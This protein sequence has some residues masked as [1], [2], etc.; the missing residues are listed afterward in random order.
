MVYNKIYKVMES[1]MENGM[2]FVL[3]CCHNADDITLAQ[4][5]YFLNECY[6]EIIRYSDDESVRNIAMKRSRMLNEHSEHV[7]TPMITEVPQEEI[8]GLD[9]KY[10]EAIDRI[11]NT[12][13]S[14]DWSSAVPRVIEALKE[15]GNNI[16]YRTMALVLQLAMNVSRGNADQSLYQSLDS[17]I[18]ATT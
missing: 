9:G 4:K 8:N 16:I 13:T 17:I 15:D 14:E 6:R 11:G 7:G 1:Y 3:G 5:K 10:N 18:K 12:I 2:N